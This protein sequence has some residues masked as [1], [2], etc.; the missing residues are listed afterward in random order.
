MVG[1][2]VAYV[3]DVGGGEEVFPR[4]LLDWRRSHVG[5]EGST[6]IL[7]LGELLYEES[8]SRITAV[9]VEV[10]DEQGRR[11]GSAK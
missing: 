7:G 2:A 11:N 10:Q 3:V 6:E 5:K 1:A 9:R 8:R 4:V